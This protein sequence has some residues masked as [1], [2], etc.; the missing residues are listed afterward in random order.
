MNLAGSVTEMNILRFSPYFLHVNALGIKFD[1]AIK[2]VKVN[3][4]SSFVLT[5]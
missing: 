5:W 2:W 3:L 1:L 4:D